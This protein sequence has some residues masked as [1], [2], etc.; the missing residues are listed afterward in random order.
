VG[1]GAGPEVFFG[2][3]ESLFSLPGIEPRF[4]G[5]PAPSLLTTRTALSRL[6]I[7]GV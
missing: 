3:E 4:L 2:E 5:R 1:P 7:Y 6:L